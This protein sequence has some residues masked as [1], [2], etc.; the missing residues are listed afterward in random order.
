[1]AADNILGKLLIEGANKM[2]GITG[3]APSLGTGLAGGEG[4][5]SRQAS[6]ER[7]TRGFQKTVKEAQLKAVGFA[8]EQPKWWTRMFK[9][10]GIQMGLAGILKQSQVF[11][12]TVGAFFQIFGAMVDVMLA[13]LVKPVLMP[14]MRWLARQIPTMG[15]LSKAIFG[16]IGSTVMR[17]V[18]WV[19]K[20]G[21][22]FKNIISL[23]F[24][25]DK[26][27]SP[28]GEFITG[29]PG[30]VWEEMK[31]LGTWSFWE[32]VLRGFYNATL[33][34]KKIGKGQFSFTFPT[35]NGGG[36]YEM[37]NVKTPG[38]VD[39]ILVTSDADGN[40]LSYESTQTGLIER[41]YDS[42]VDKEGNI[43][44]DHMGRDVLLGIHQWMK[45][46][47]GG[48]LEGYQ[49]YKEKWKQDQK[50]SIFDP[51]DY[52]T[53]A[54][55]TAGDVKELFDD[56]PGHLKAAAVAAGVYMTP[57]LLTKIISNAK[58][59]LALVTRGVMAPAQAL[60]G[61]MRFGLQQ[62]NVGSRESVINQLFRSD[63]KGMSGAMKAA[64]GEFKANQMHDI[65]GTTAASAGGKMNVRSGLFDMAEE[66]ADMGGRFGGS[67]ADSLLTRAQQL[68]PDPR[69]AA[70]TADEIGGQG[71]AASENLL[72]RGRKLVKEL[73]SYVLTK[74]RN[75]GSIIKNPTT[76]KTIQSTIETM[77][78]NIDD[79]LRPIYLS[80]PEASVL[81]GAARSAKN[82]LL[83][84]L[85]V[86]GA[87]VGLAETAYNIKQI[88]GSDISWWKPEVEGNAQLQA[89][90]KRMNAIASGGADMLKES[91]DLG[92]GP[93]DIAKKFI[94]STGGT[95]AL[96]T[97]ALSGASQSMTH[98]RTG[99]ILTQLLLGGGATTA[100]A[101]GLPGLPVSMGM[102]AAQELHRGAVM[103]NDDHLIQAMYDAFSQGVLKKDRE[104]K[105]QIE[106]FNGVMDIPGY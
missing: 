28:I 26:V 63:S 20:I 64:L 48:N 49:A 53:I 34:G 51:G 70:A 79:L 100:G 71:A 17:I 97:S 42:G 3:G 32:A 7:E 9:T 95:Q 56:L 69:A 105:I 88:A 46:N 86:V 75:I 39:P 92:W 82:F 5:G 72:V 67:N 73:T 4:G 8:K 54:K 57:V 13:P 27:V 74:L 40:A 37:E 59:A 55:E 31:K 30:A 1:M 50:M 33:G 41:A 94:L 14:V 98:T 21:G 15:R 6:A 68:F 36:T 60:W 12:S 96:E 44:Q 99:A 2:G 61:T 23:D 84:S 93:M 87:A 58:N 81:V 83:R 76:V 52:G 90:I 62:L 65:F 89:D 66:A 10:L 19:V 25:K 102:G 47:T 11:T 45:M 78:Q 103:Q 43:K 85:P 38:H 29:L 91:A 24:W 16:F 77:F 80:V 22:W 101:I 106:G 35:W 104:M 18:S